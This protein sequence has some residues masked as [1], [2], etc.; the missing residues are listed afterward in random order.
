MDEINY[1]RST[2]KQSSCPPSDDSDEYVYS[3]TG[4]KI[5]K[6]ERYGW[7]MQDSP[8]KFEYIDKKLLNIDDIY[9]R[10]AKRARILNL[11]REWSWAACGTITVANRNGK[12]YVVDGQHRVL[13]AKSRND[14]ERLPCLVLGSNGTRDEADTWIKANT[15]RNSPSSIE[16]FKALKESGD[17]DAIYLQDQFD[18]LKIRITSHA[19][20]PLEIQSIQAPLNIIHRDKVQFY[21][22]VNLISELCKDSPINEWILSGLDYIGEKHDLENQRLHDRILKIGPH[23]ITESA[24]EAAAYYKRGGRKI[25]AYGILREIN[26]GLRQRF[27]IDNFDGWSFAEDSQ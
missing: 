2:N 16:R 26:R 5:L 10:K 18:R 12:L 21:K 7:G 27:Y 13:A 1:K 17:V 3:P 22:L 6:T 25:W 15:H 24:K 14:I 8:G 9:Q 23:R 4:T 19:K 11:A 20:N